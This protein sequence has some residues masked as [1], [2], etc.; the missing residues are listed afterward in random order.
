MYGTTTGRCRG[1]GHANVQL[2][3]LPEIKQQDVGVVDAKT[4][5][6]GS[7]NT[8]WQILEDRTEDFR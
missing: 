4:V 8:T 3:D 2:L 7:V 6:G 1:V 5:R